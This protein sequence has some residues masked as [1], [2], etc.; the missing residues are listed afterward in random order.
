MREISGRPDI[1]RLEIPEDMWTRPFWEGSRGHRLM[2][3]HCAECHAFRWPPGP[4]CPVCRSQ[5]VA[6]TDA[7][8]GRIY[9]FTIVRAVP[10]KEGGAPQTLSPALIEFPDAGGMRVLAAVVDSPIDRIAIGAE[11]APVWVKA[12]NAIV[13]MFTLV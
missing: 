10:A 12:A 9:S 4:F 13:P 1:S 8:A 2:L 11:V 5:Q 3:P 6:W 7:G